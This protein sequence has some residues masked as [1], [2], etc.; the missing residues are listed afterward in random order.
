MTD[1]VVELINQSINVHAK[2]Q[3]LKIILKTQPPVEN[4]GKYDNDNDYG[5][6]VP[7]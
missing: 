3:I 2:I 1:M 4:T 5:T 7:F 6:N